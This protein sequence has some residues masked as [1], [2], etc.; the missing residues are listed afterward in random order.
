MQK[1]DSLIE[2]LKQQADIYNYLLDK[3]KEKT[4]IIIE[5]K[6]DELDRITKLENTLVS[7]IAKM[8]SRREALVNK[9]AEEIG[10]TSDQVTISELI[11]KID[12]N[13]AEE[14]EGL[15]NR[16]SGI[17]NELKNIN[18]LN[19]MLIKNSLEYAE[20]SLNILSTARVSDNNYGDSGKVSGP[21]NR[22]FFDVKL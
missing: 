5:G 14:L 13:E 10:T 8:E 9:I 6:V 15:R 2:I 18:E 21:K 3:S 19:S 7:D 16:I 20:F 1:I 12:K 11:K 22:S 4:D 17:L